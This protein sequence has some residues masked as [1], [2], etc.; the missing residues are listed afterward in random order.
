[1]LR[2]SPLPARRPPASL[3]VLLALSLVLGGCAPSGTA[4]PNDSVSPTLPPGAEARSARPRELEPQA[5]SEAIAALAAGNRA[6]A[7]DLYQA[8][9]GEEGNL[10]FS[11]YSI[12]LALAMT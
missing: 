9:R 10:F 5:S 8:V 7:L 2:P 4:T 12:S 11:P 6:F 3:A 1:M